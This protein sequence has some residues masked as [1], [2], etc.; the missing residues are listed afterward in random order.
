MEILG[1]IAELGR[2]ATP[3]H[4]AIGV[5]D[6]I[7]LGHQAVIGRAVAGARAGGGSSVVVTFHPHPEKVLRPDKAPR[8]LTSAEHKV[9]L[10]R[11]LGVDYLLVVPF[12]EAFAGTEA[13]DFVHLLAASC[14]KLASVCVGQSWAFGKG[15][16]GNVE[17]LTSLGREL[18]FEVHGVSSVDASGEAD[19]LPVSS[20]RIRKAVLEGDLAL[21]ARLLGRPYTLLGTVLHGRALGRKLGFPTANL[22]TH[23]EQFPP[24]GV[25]AVRATLYG[26][27]QD[28]VLSGVANLGHRPTIEDP[29]VSKLL[30][31]VH[32]FDFAED[33]YGRELEVE[34]VTKLRDEMKFSGIEE[35]RAQIDRDS[36]EAR[37]IL[38]G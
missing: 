28:R 14:G 35:L 18:G 4:L 16:R 21:A 38:L 13:Q 15:A 23:N 20:T 37:R 3:A 11:S 12:D 24:T 8:L 19:P 1:T 25:Y 22:L 27:A 31:E 32:L 30:L 29:A 9:R 7:H 34:F 17:L 6:G 10:I 2:L 36:A 26:G 5:F 33:I